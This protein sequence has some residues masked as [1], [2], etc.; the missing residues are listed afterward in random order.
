M[1]SFLF[2]KRRYPNVKCFIVYM[3]GE[4]DPLLLELTAPW[5]EGIYQFSPH[6]DETSDFVK[7]IQE[8]VKQ[9]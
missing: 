7:L 2:L 4:I 6:K 5:I 1:P 9:S 3:V 8:A